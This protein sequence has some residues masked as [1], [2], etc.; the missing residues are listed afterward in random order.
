MFGFQKEVFLAFMKTTGVA[1]AAAASTVMDL[2]FSALLMFTVPTKEGCASVL[3]C[4]E[5]FFW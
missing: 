5:A 1:A 4:P 2:D 3:W